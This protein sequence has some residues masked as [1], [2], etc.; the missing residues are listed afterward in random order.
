MK[1]LLI[2]GTLALSLVGA[3]HANTPTLD[4]HGGHW[5]IIGTPAYSASCTIVRAWEDLSAVAYC[6]EDGA[7]YHYDPDGNN[8]PQSVPYDGPRWPAGWYPA[9]TN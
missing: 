6:T 1:S 9:G 5:P 4:Y 8:P 7:T 3:A 2:A